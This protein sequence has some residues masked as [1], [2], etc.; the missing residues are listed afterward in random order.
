MI[1]HAK[2][3][4]S[5]RHKEPRAA[6]LLSFCRYRMSVMWFIQPLFPFFYIYI[7]HIFQWLFSTSNMIT[8]ETLIL[9]THSH[10]LRLR[11]A[12]N[13]LLQCYICYECNWTEIWSF[14]WIRHICAPHRM[15]Q[16]AHSHPWIKLYCVIFLLPL[17]AAC[18]IC[19]VINTH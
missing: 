19:D 14:F 18:T 5:L 4:Q 16:R 17:E 8:A 6:D 11:A 1:S 9:I 13:G 2:Q 3:T 10:I 7:S 12:Q 15:N